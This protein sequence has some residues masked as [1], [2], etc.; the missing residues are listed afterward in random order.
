MEVEPTALLGLISRC[1]STAQSALEQS[2]KRRGSVQPRGLQRSLTLRKVIN[3]K[4]QLT[5]NQSSN[6]Y[7]NHCRIVLCRTGENTISI[8]EEIV[9][10]NLKFDAWLECIFIPGSCISFVCS[11]RAE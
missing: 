9:D 2:L 11:I 10:F 4:K 8:L 7:C 5:K 3:F 1:E 6:S